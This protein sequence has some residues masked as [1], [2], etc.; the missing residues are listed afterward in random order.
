MTRHGGLVAKAETLKC[1]GKCP[2]F[3]RKEIMLYL[4]GSGG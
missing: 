2:E 4:E 3:L 1:C